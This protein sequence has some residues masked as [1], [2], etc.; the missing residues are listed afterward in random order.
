MGESDRAVPR[1]RLTT[2]RYPVWLTVGKGHQHMRH[3]RV[4]FWEAK[5]EET[6]TGAQRGAFLTSVCWTGVLGAFG[7]RMRSGETRR[8]RLWAEE[9]TNARNR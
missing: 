2:G 5:P 9:I 4:E 7:V 3:A 1:S 6:A 8:F